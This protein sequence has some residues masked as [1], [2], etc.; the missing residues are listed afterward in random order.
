MKKSTHIF[1]ILLIAFI[2]IMITAFYGCGNK[3][4]AIAKVKPEKIEISGDLADYIQV[5]DNEY[6]ITDDWGGNLSIKVKAIQALTEEEMKNKDFEISA[7]L[8]DNKSMPVSGVGEFKIEYESKDKLLSLLKKGSGEEVIQLKAQLGDYEAEEHAE[9]SKMFTVS[10]T[11]K[12]QEKP[13]VSSTESSDNSTAS[14][15][16]TTSSTDCD[17]FLIDYEA[18]ADS[19]IKLLKK[20]KKDPSDASILTEYT[21]AAQKAIE[22]QNNVA[23][24][25]DVK[26]ATKLTKIATKIANAAADLQ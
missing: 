24:C 11:M 18:F 13:S 14:D 25:T 17:Q 2:A 5:V 4:S 26:Y 8:L 3:K 15:D 6:E 20:Y 19:Y 7:S 16:N 10:S 21:E 12:E 22:M 23:N 9:K 1:S